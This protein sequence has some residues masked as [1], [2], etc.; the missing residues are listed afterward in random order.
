M[1][2]FRAYAERALAGTGAFALNFAAKGHGGAHRPLLR[3]AGRHFD[4]ARAFRLGA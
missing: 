2:R 3:N 4:A 1:I